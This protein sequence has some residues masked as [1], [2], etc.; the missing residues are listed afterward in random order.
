MTTVNSTQ[1]AGGTSLFS[2]STNNAITADKEL[3]LKLL[4]TQL[5]NQDPM[6]PLKDQ[7]FVAQLA[8]FT[9]LEKLSAID[10]KMSSF[11]S[12]NGNL[13]AMSMIDRTVT[14]ADV[15]TGETIEGKV[16]SVR[17]IGD[18]APSITMG[19]IEYPISWVISAR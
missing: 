15:N 1:N 3:F 17:L 6:D 10:E 13:H 9:S 8:Q 11:G 18:N 19:G 7:D 16:S 14:V 2:G 12:A 5:K 4:I